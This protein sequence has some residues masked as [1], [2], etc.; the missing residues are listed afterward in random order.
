[1]KNSCFRLKTINLKT[2]TFFKEGG[3]N[4]IVILLLYYYIILF[5]FS[6]SPPKTKNEL[7]ERDKFEVISILD[8]IY[9]LDQEGRI[10]LRE[11]KNGLLSSELYNFKKDSLE[12]IQ[13]NIDDNNTRL[14][15]DIT[16][17]YG[18]PNV[19][20]IGKPIP[21]WLI[22]QHS[23]K[24]Y[25]SELEKLLDNENKSRRLPDNEYAMIKWHISGRKASP[26][27]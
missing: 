6:C 5:N 1:M 3:C 27:K 21:A 25:F 24:D 23:S 2:T 16:K 13:M 15:I 18:F 9:T 14:L 12:K 22:F 7:L 26:F 20:R 19:E 17:K 10:K 8:E 11:L 4:E